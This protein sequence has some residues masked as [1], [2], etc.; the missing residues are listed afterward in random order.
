M[1]LGE[2]ESAARDLVGPEGR[3]A[4]LRSSSRRRASPSQNSPGPPTRVAL[5]LDPE[6]RASAAMADEPKPARPARKKRG[7]RPREEFVDYIVA[8]EGW[9][10]SY[11]LSLNGDRRA[12]DPYHEFRHLQI[13]GR[14]LHPTGLKTDRFE[15]TLLPSCDLGLEARKQSSPL[16]VG[17]LDAYGDRLA[18][19][20]SIP[21]DALP[22]ILQMMIG[23]R[24]KFIAMR[25]DRLKR[26]RALFRSFRL[27]MTMDEHDMPA[28]ESA[29]DTPRRCGGWSCGTLR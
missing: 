2:F 16:C 18:G 4:I 8:I 17:S 23:E 5:V 21:M 27:E 29:V 3:L 11:S 19:L 24:F 28:T 20:M 26:R 22:P 1:E 13:R 15:L 25:G 14:L 12:V 6:R 7:R 9:D 10:W